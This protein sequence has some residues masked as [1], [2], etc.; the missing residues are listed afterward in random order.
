MYLWITYE[1]AWAAAW[2]VALAFWAVL[3][4]PTCVRRGDC[5]VDFYSWNAHGFNLA[6]LLIETIFNKS[7]L[8][9]RGLV[10]LIQF[11]LGYHFAMRMC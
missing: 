5:S 9:P 7:V 8:P 4:L 10:E 6:L 11:V 1:M 3:T 2:F